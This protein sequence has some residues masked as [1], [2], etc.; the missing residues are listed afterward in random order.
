VPSVF[1]ISIQSEESPFSSAC[2]WVFRATNSEIRGT[3]WSGDSRE[4]TPTE[5][6]SRKFFVKM[7]IEFCIGLIRTIPTRNCNGLFVSFG[8]IKREEG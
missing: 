2:E 8:L 7:K 5:P 4:A 3:A 6:N 1:S